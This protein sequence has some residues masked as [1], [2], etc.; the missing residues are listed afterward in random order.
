M[1]RHRLGLVGVA[2]VLALA[3]GAA[4]EDRVKRRV[5]DI[6]DEAHGATCA[7]WLAWR[8]R[9]SLRRSG[10]FEIFVPAGQAVKPWF[11]IGVEHLRSRRRWAVDS[12]W[13]EAGTTHRVRRLV[14]KNRAPALERA[15]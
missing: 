4:R 12:V 9:A 6:H 14:G 7:A 15:S 10:A 5:E 1:P 3:S 8:F 11:R 13:S 2:A